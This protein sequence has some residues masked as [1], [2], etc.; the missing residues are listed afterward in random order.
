MG[1]YLYGQRWNPAGLRIVYLAEHLSLAALE[2]IVH[3]GTYEDLSE[4]RAFRARFDDALLEVLEQPRPPGW[5]AIEPGR[6]SQDIGARWAAR[7][8]T[9]L[10]RV[11]SV[12]I[13]HEHNY[14]LHVDDPRWTEVS[15]E[16]PRPFAFDPRLA[17]FN[18]PPSGT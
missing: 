12:V 8:Q 1:S 13:Q 3:A 17:H 9:P 6:T 4:Y 10:L 18:Q 14:L 2:V 5:D 15:I 11:P 7:Q 16:G